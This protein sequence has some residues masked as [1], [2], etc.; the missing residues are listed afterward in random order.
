MQLKNVLLLFFVLQISG[1]LWSQ[2][3]TTLIQDANRTFEAINWHEDGRIYVVDFNNG[4]LYQAYTDGTIETIATG[5][6]N[7]AGGGFDA[8]GTFYFSDLSAGTVHRLNEDGTT[9]QVA[10][11]LSQPTGILGS[12]SPDT[13]FVGQYANN[14]VAKLALGSGT[15]SNWV[16]GN[17][18]SGTDGVIYGPA[19]DVLVANFNNNRISKVTLSGDVSLFA[20]IP[21]TGFMGYIT[22]AGDDVYVPSIAGNKIYRIDTDGNSTI[23]AGSG[24][25]GNADGTG[26]MATFNDPNGICSSPSGDTLLVTDGN[27][28]RMITQLNTVSSEELLPAYESLSIYPNPVGKV[29]NIS[30]ELSA[31]QHIHWQIF[32]QQGQ[33]VR[34]GSAG[35]LTEGKQQLEL[36]ISGL[37]AG[38]YHLQLNDEQQQYRWMSHFVKM[39]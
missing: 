34:N 5:F 12:N 38:D 19:G 39:K 31:T 7:L 10:S 15:V 30:F 22:L 3:V 13:L 36:V 24:S 37:A 2:V 8:E 6:S 21:S 26:E 18:I 16:S 23:A 33:L 11:G 14:S 9:T 20:T 1:Q 32:N 28:I 35:Q 27:R 17:G 4:R 25:A 29:L